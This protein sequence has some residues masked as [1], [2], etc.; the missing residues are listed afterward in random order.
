MKALTLSEQI[1]SHAAGR[2]VRAGD[3]VI[4]EVDRCMTHDS[5]TPEVIDVLREQL[6]A[7]NVFDPNRVAVI[8]DH[9]APASSVA[10]ADAQ[11]RVRRWVAEE[12][13]SH[14]YDVGSGVCHQVMIEEGLVQPGQIVLG[15]DSH[16]TSYGAVCAFG[17]GVGTRDMALALASGRIWL[18]VPETLRVQVGGS[19]CPWVSAK[20]LSLYLCGKLGLDG[21]TYQ[22]IEFHG[23]AWLGL[24]GRETL[25][26]M[27]TELGAKAGLVPPSGEVL[28]RFDVPD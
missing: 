13:I 9:V 2:Q 5:L 23:V 20:D 14:F 22:A 28:D 24:D 10:T 15:T 18:R 25:C 27:T 11:V 26:S 21:A 12:G 6:G 8:V 7:K 19:F 3:L 17:T 16:S 1:L 4:I